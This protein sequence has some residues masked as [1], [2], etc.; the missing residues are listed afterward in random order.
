M[1]SLRSQMLV[2]ALIGSAMAGVAA[3]DQAGPPRRR[4]L[5]DGPDTIRDPVTPS[6]PPAPRE[7]DAERMAAAEAKRARKNAKRAAQFNREPA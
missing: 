3:I 2:A 4:V 5:L 1:R 7:H 6:D